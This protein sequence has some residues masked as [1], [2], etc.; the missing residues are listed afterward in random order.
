MLFVR[1][2]L[3][4]DWRNP[5]YKLTRQQLKG[6]VRLMEEMELA[7]NQ[8]QEESDGREEADEEGEEE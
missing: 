6:L 5:E 2:Q 7:A 8:D 3:E 1:T 4:N